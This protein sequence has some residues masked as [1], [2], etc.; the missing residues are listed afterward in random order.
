MQ[1]KDSRLVDGVAGGWKLGYDGHDF[2]FSIYT[3]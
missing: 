3:L 2:P 1:V